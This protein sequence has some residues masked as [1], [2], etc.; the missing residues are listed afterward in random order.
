M[1]PGQF[2]VLLLNKP[3]LL[4]QG[5]HVRAG[6]AGRSGFVQRSQR[7]PEELRETIGKARGEREAGEAS[8][9]R[10]QALIFIERTFEKT[11]HS[12]SEGCVPNTMLQGACRQPRRAILMTSKES[13]PSAPSNGQAKDVMLQRKQGSASRRPFHFLVPDLAIWLLT[14]PPFCLN[15]VGASWNTAR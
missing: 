10:C 13:K 2:L 5:L 8:P 4:V 3:V 15:I 14:D 6:E 7:R 11:M 9:S 12:T 1:S